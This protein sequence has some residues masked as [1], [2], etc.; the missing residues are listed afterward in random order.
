MASFPV[1]TEFPPVPNVCHGETTSTPALF[2]LTGKTA[3][4]TGGN[5]GIGSGMTR[6]LAESGADIIILQIPGEQSDFAEQLSSDTSRKVFVYECD[7]RSNE[8][9]KATVQDII[10]RDGHTVDILC[11]CAG[12][13]GGFVPVLDETVEHRELVG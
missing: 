9:I 6:G 4:V 5:G 7:L 2:G 13:S 12:I 1:Q 3:L 10:E 11:N 8:M